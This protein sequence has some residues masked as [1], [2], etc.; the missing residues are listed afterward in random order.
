MRFKPIP[1]SIRCASI[2][3][4]WITVVKMRSGEYRAFATD[5]DYVQ[6]AI[7][8]PGIEELEAHIFYNE[9]YKGN[10]PIYE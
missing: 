2:D 10:A 4:R 9:D 1:D 8:E 5:S 6:H 3:A 7:V